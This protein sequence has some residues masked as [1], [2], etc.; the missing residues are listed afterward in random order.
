VIIPT[1]FGIN[2]EAETAHAF[3]LAGADPLEIHLNDLIARPE[4]LASAG[5]LVLAGGFSFGDHLGAGKVFAN[6]LRRR[7]GQSVGAFV[8]RGGLVLGICNGFQTLARL[9]LVPDGSLG[10]QAVALAPNSHGCF[11]DGWVTLAVD[12]AS[13]CLF[14]KGLERLE[15]PVRH[16]EGRLLTSPEVL[17]VIRAQH[18]A[19]VRYADPGTDQPTGVFPA[20]P[21]G[22]LDSIAG[23]CDCS[24]RIFGLMPHPEAF[25]YPECHPLW[26]WRQERPQ[27][28][29]LVIF[30]NAVQEAV[31]CK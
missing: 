28:E 20:N 22:S 26:R 10:S 23:L 29:G 31:G 21:N 30:Q 11:H 8:E 9:G 4:A 14:T 5:I 13:P 18:L 24:G 6:R 1:G 17:E 19:P 2:C 27:G 16:G 25:L 3:K 15:V 7:L 12:P